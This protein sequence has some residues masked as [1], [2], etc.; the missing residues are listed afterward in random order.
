MKVGMMMQQ[1][2]S[3]QRAERERDNKTF[4]VK[5][6]IFWLNVKKIRKFVKK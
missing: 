6:G 5:T 3:I 2:Y 4:A 1:N